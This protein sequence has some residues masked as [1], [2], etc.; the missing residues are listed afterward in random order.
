M[1]EKFGWG[2]RKQGKKDGRQRREADAAGRLLPAE[3]VIFAF[4]SSQETGQNVNAFPRYSKC[5]S[6]TLAVK[7][8]YKASIP[9]QSQSRIVLHR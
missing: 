7:P 5:M 3:H 2:Q 6:E 9:K 1:I 8:L 4:N